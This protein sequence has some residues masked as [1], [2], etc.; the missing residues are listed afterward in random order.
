MTDKLNEYIVWLVK[1]NPAMKEPL[2]NCLEKLQSEY[3]VFETIDA[4]S[5]EIFE[6]WGI[7]MGVKLLL[8]TQKK[9]WTHAKVRE[10]A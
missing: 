4:V 5:H 8:K 6:E 1:I 3:I 2:E 7:S 10:R 9:K